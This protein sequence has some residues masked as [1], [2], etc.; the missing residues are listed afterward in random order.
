MRDLFLWSSLVAWVP[1]R[2]LSFLVASGLGL[3]LTPLI[4]GD[5]S[6][7]AGFQIG[8]LAGTGQ[9]P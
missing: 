2:R 6:S 8:R 7:R 3:P 1:A 9:T 5:D 4:A